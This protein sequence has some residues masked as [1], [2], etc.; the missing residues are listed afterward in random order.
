[1]FSVYKTFQQTVKCSHQGNHKLQHLTGLEIYISI[2]ASKT[3]IQF[4]TGFQQPETSLPK[5]P[6]LTFI[7]HS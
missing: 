6:V 7:I 1:M 4:E 3:E 5:R 2:K